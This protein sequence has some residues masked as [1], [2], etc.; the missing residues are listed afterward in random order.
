MTPTISII[1]LAAGRSERFGKD[2]KLLQPFGSSDTLLDATITRALQVATD[3]VVVVTG[4]DHEHVSPVADRHP[5]RVVHNPLFNQGMGASIK[6]GVQTVHPGHAIMIWPADMPLVQAQTVRSLMSHTMPNLIVR[7]T[8]MGN[9]G[10]PVLFGI[11]HRD[12]LLDIPDSEGAQSVLQENKNDV[13][14]VSVNDAGV[15]QDFDTP[16]DF[17]PLSPAP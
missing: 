3:D 9:P 16:D 14:R 7:P 17:P 1:L 8:F 6:A 4:H 11:L 2:N 10:H 12:R 5:V 13:V 15:I